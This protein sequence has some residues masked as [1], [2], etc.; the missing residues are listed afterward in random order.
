MIDADSK[1]DSLSTF[2]IFLYLKH[3]VT[4]N[5]SFLLFFIFA[6]PSPLIAM[7]IDTSGSLVAG[8]EFNLTCVVSKLF[9]GLTG[10]PMATWTAESIFGTELTSSATDMA[11]AVLNINPLRNSYPMLYICSGSYFSPAE[12][13]TH[14]VE[15]RRD[16]RVQSK[17][18]DAN[19]IYNYAWR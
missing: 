11:M 7:S 17:F 4:T 15:E 13:R 1:S 18:I 19:L 16:I 2:V 8:S 3:V 9:T 5:N 6:V 14:V 12:N 10:S